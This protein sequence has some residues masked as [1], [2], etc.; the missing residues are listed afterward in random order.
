MGRILPKE[1]QNGILTIMQSMWSFL[2]YMS[3]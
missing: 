3:R 1:L 2:L